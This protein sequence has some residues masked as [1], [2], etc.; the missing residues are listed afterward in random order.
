MK[1]FNQNKT[2]QIQF[3]DL[4]KGYLEDDKIQIGQTLAVAEVKEQGHFEVVREYP[5]GGK[6]SCFV[7]DVPYAAPK[8]SEPIFEDIKVYIPYSADELKLRQEQRFYE[9]YKNEFEALNKAFEYLQSTDYMAIKFAEG[10]ISAQEYE[11]I[12][13]QRR[14]KRE[15]IN[16]LKQLLAQK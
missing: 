9:Q 6:D 2:M 12:K 5:N 10:E 11:P 7:V 1:I 16:R 3:P 15:E 8:E 4:E 13:Q 14:S